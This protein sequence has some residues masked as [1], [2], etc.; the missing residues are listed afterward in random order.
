LKK[1]Y[2]DASAIIKL[3]VPEAE[4]QS[5]IDYL[6]EQQLWAVTSV[7]ADVEVRRTLQ[8]F[9]SLGADVE[10]HVRGFFLIELSRDI[11]DRA[12]ALGPKVRSLDAIHLSTALALEEEVDFV[13]YDNRLAAAAREHGLRVIQPGC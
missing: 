7:V 11:R 8:R 13:T 4:S 1:A 6:A 10:E 3:G 5:L 9:K 12:V 2:F